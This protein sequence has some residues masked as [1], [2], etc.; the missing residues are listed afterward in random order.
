[1]QTIEVQKGPW[2]HA[3]PCYECECIF[4]SERELQTHID[5]VHRENLDSQTRTLTLT[6]F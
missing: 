4:S 6:V 1:M 2:P 3:F 5:Q